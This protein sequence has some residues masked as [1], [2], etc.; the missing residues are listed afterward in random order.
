[1]KYKEKNPKPRI[2][3]AITF[4]ELIG[5]GKTPGS[6][7]NVA[8][9]NESHLVVTTEFN[10]TIKVTPEDVLIIEKHRVY[11]MIDYIF[12]EYYELVN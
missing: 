4:N 2:I 11:T 8:Y 9:K 6:I 5:H 3:E 10:E 1:M 7:R 12:K